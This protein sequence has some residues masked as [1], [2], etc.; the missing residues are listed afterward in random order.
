M[1]DKEQ[2]KPKQICMVPDCDSEARWKGICPKCY[3]QAR[4][5]IE[6]KKTTWDE[7]AEMG[8]CEIGSKKLLMAFIKLKQTTFEEATKPQELSVVG[9]ALGNPDFGKVIDQQ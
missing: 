3:H 8:L 2:S 5:L 1:A 9:G 7:L 6:N 4:T